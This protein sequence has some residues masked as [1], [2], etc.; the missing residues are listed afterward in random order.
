TRTTVLENRTQFT[1]LPT[2]G[3]IRGNDFYFIANSQIDNL[4]GNKVMDVTRLSAVRI[5]VVHLP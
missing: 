2:T 4:N 5:A 1:V 3:A